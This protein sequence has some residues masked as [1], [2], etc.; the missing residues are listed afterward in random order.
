MNTVGAWIKAHP[1]VNVLAFERNY[2]KSF[3]FGSMEEVCGFCLASHY[4]DREPPELCRFCRAPIRESHLISDLPEVVS[5]IYRLGVPSALQ[6][7]SSRPSPR[8]FIV[9]RKPKGKTVPNS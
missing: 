3:G 1:G 4:F 8:P 6:G 5:V 2:G 9:W 7:E